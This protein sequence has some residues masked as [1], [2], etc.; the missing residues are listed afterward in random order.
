MQVKNV[1]AN[2]SN[3]WKDII[4]EIDSLTNGM[5]ER[6]FERSSWKSY[7]TLA[8]N[9]FIKMVQLI[10]MVLKMMMNLRNFKTSYVAIILSTNSSE[11]VD[12][13]SNEL[14]KVLC[15]ECIDKLRALIVPKSRRQFTTIC[16]KPWQ[17]K[18]A[19]SNCKIYWSSKDLNQRT[20][21][22]YFK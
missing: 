16:Q 15:E 11:K 6:G 19:R 17:Q 10:L 21:Y 13:E 4:E 5:V 8:E 12:V 1:I 7:Q 2:Q 22:D 14:E 20:I 18:V 3:T 9:G